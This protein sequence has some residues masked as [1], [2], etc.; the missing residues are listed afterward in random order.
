MKNVCVKIRAVLGMNQLIVVLLL[1]MIMD[2]N[3]K[4]VL[5]PGIMAI[6]NGMVSN[7]AVAVTGKLICLRAIMIPALM[8]RRVKRGRVFQRDPWACDDFQNPDS[9]QNCVAAIGSGCTIGCPGAKTIYC[10]C[11]G[12]C[13][14]AKTLPACQCPPSSSASTSSS[15]GTP[16][17]SASTSSSSGTPSSSA[18]TSS[19]S[20]TP[21]S[22]GGG[23]GEGVDNELLS[24][25]EWN[26][27]R[28]ANQTAALSDIQ[29]NTAITAGYV[30]SIDK[31]QSTINR[32]NI[33]NTDRI[34]ASI[35]SASGALA[36]DTALHGVKD[37]LHGINSNV[38]A[39]KD[40]LLDSSHGFDFDISAWQDKADS[41]MNKLENPESTIVYI[42][43]LKN[44]TSAFK[45]SYSSFFLH[46]VYTRNGCYEFKMPRPDAT[47]IFGRFFRSDIAVNFGAVGGFDFLCNFARAMPYSGRNTCTSHIY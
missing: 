23:S 3:I 42:D 1:A 18:S 24:K 36:T 19:S 31:W 46:D 40:A 26:T 10:D 4:S 45:T 27:R 44:D 8:L 43:S 17:S 37:S 30:S 22:S 20:G 41:V 29:Q 12:S 9:T 11:D 34:I 2:P 5:K 13:D 21:S 39:I 14:H 35:E 15:S 32:N 38:G 25:I 6:M 16:S 28:T 47:S 7:L 33:Q